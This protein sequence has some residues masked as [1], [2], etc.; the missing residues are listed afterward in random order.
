MSK[1]LRNLFNNQDD[2]FLTQFSNLKINTIE[3]E[4]NMTEIARIEA[5]LAQLCTKNAE[6]EKK[7][8]DLTNNQ[9]IFQN[10]N[11]VQVTEYTDV[12]PTYANGDA[13]QL[14]A[15]KVIPEFS[16]DR[17]TYRSWRSQ[18]SKLMNHIDAFK[19]HPKYAAALS[20]IRAKITGTASDI[21]INNDTKHNIAA[22]IFVLGSKTV[23]RH[24]S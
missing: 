7:V 9:T 21:L 23:V 8:I 12:V 4:V 15:F 18:V 19:T 13:I 24:R 20:I 14:D 22:I 11:A 2:S 3:E 16:G 6:L 5:Q 17:K 10:A 1:R